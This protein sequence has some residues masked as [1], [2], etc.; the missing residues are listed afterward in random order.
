MGLSIGDYFRES[1]RPFGDPIGLY[2]TDKEQRLQNKLG[3]VFNDEVT[4]GQITHLRDQADRFGGLRSQ[5]Q[6]GINNAVNRGRAKLGKEAGLAASLKF[7]DQATGA[8]NPNDVVTNALRRAKARVGIVNRGDEALRNQQLQDRLKQVKAGISARG[9]GIQTQTKAQ[10][11]MSGVN[12]AASDA[13][14]RG[15]AATADMAGGIAG[16]FAGLLKANKDDR[17]GMFNFFG[18]GG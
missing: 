4:R 10:N 5:A 18:G 13:A 7:G 16:S 3:D 6:A 1:L 15:R 14:A 8:V 11:I 9:R 2:Q 12:V 17:G